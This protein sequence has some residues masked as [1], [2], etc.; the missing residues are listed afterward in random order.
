MATDLRSRL[1]I[2]EEGLAGFCK[3]WKITKLELFGSAL[4]DDFGQDS[5]LDFL[6][7]FDGEARW[8]LLDHIRMED[9][10]MAIASRPVD[11]ITRRSVESDRNWIRR[12]KILG[13]TQLLYAA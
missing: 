6:V 1:A 8:S 11:M 3:K 7:T 13:N 4:R 10:L 2:S 9:D 5:D 12:K